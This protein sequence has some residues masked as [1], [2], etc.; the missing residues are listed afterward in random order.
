M[1]ALF[2]QGLFL[3]IKNLCLYFRV[4]SF[5]SFLELLWLENSGVGLLEA[6]GIFGGF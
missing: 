3:D 6:L 4:I 5:N 1:V 2:E